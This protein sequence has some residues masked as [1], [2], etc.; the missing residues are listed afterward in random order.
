[1]V[2]LILIS[3]ATIIISVNQSFAKVYVCNQDPCTTWK[4]IT[5]A[6]LAMES[7]DELKTRVDV[8]LTNSSNERIIKGVTSDNVNLYLKSNLWHKG[9][10]APKQ[11]EHLTAYVY[12]D[13]VHVSSCHIHSY[14]IK[15]YDPYFTTCEKK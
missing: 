12:E 1:M 5:N 4:P 10:G 15:L 7:F 9:G 3:L 2:K 14:K 6:Q 13:D 11:Y 8:A